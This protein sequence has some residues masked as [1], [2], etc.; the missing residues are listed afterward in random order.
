[1]GRATCVI[2]VAVLLFTVV[3]SGCLNQESPVNQQPDSNK[4]EA[5]PE[6]M[7]TQ[8]TDVRTG[9]QFTISS[10]K[11][12]PVL[13]ESFAVWCPTCTEQQR[14][15]KKLK[16]LEG[17]TIVHISLDTDPNED[18]NTVLQHVETYGFDWYYAVSPIEMTRSLIGDYGTKVVFAPGVPMILICP[19]QSAR[20]LPGGVKTPE[21]LLSEIG[22]GC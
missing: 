12:K 11:G 6:W 10:F 22:S 9:K 2:A 3:L 18:A 21:K 20:L 1:M 13:L 5:L 19:D 8:L 16:E 7:N 17:D 4:F 14:Q 15:T